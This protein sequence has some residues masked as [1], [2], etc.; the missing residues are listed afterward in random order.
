[1][2]DRTTPMCPGWKI[3]RGQKLQMICH[4]QV[5]SRSGK[6]VHQLREG[7]PHAPETGCFGITVADKYS[8][9]QG[10]V[11]GIYTWQY[12]SKILVPKHKG[13][14]VMTGGNRIEK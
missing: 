12:D 9:Y 10:N 8:P 7:R 13:N 1:M 5:S 4:S 14:V 11:C 6:N 3:I 2:Q